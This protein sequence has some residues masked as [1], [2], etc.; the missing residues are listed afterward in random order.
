MTE[1]G[2]NM[3]NHVQ[4]ILRLKR[5][6]VLG[7]S[8]NPAKFGYRI[9]TVLK[10][11][12][13]EVYPVN[14]RESMLEGERCYS[15]LSELPV[16]PDVVDFVVPPSAAIQSLAQ[17]KALGIQHIWLQPGVNTPEVIAQ[18]QTL[19]LSGIMDGSCA[20]VESSKIA[21][22]QQKRWAV[23]GAAGGPAQAEGLSSQLQQ[24]RYQASLLL[25][26][27]TS[28][29]NA[30]VP[31]LA[32]LAEKPAGALIAGDSSLVAGALQDCK[33]AGV[34]FAW[35]QKGSESDALID[36]GFSLDLIIVHHADVITEIETIGTDGSLS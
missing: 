17:C 20:M 10:R 18:A 25:A 5:W 28:D 29:G 9:F 4:E 23:I 30:I 11:Y 26:L 36:L 24:R 16:V 32:S 21:M 1:W 14:P 6:A 7:A 15:S 22:L 8:A 35:I 12:G 27:P 19:Q 3:N 31:S 13:Y 34:D 2:D 33:S